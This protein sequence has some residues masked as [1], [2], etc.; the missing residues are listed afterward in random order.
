MPF[1]EE[2]CRLSVTTIIGEIAMLSYV[3]GIGLPLAA[4][5]LFGWLV[6]EPSAAPRGP[7][8]PAE[9]SP[10][11]SDV[12]LAPGPA[13]LGWTEEDDLL[14]AQLLDNPGS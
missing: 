12:P 2:R 9:H 10:R 11:G 8:Q 4:L 14:V 13:G 1:T 7:D 5:V 6:Y 3:L